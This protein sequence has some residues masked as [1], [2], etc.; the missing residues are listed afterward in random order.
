MLT[1]ESDKLQYRHILNCTHEDRFNVL[2]W[3]LSGILIELQRTHLLLIDM[4]SHAKRE[5]KT[6]GTRCNFKIVTARI[7][8]RRALTCYK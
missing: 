7:Q 3:S 8:I 1:D 5:T 2:L 6:S 4:T